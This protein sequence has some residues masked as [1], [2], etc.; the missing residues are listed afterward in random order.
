[1]EVFNNVKEKHRRNQKYSTFKV[2]LSVSYC[3][4]DSNLKKSGP[5]IYQNGK[6]V[7]HMTFLYDEVCDSDH[8]S[9]CAKVQKKDI[10]LFT[11]SQNK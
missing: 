11:S 3:I 2:S 6:I 4:T 1:M 5:W 7:F 10:D 9:I 8:Y